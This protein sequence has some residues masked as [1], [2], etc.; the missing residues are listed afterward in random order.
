MTSIDDANE[1]PVSDCEWNDWIEAHTAQQ[2]L[3]PPDYGLSKIAAFLGTSVALQHYFDGAEFESGGEY[4]NAA[5]KYSAAYRLWPSLD[6]IM[7]GGLPKDAREEAI[8]KG[9]LD[10]KQNVLF[11]VIDITEA[12]ASKVVSST[13]RLLND[14]DLDLVDRVKNSIL[15]SESEGTNNPQNSW[16]SHK[17]ACMMNNPPFYA[18]HTSAPQIIGKLLHFAEQ[19]WEAGDWSGPN[20]PLRNLKHGIAGLSIR[21]AE[22]WQYEE[23]GGLTDPFHYDTDS[24]L[25]IVALLS[26]SGDFDGGAFRTY[27]SDNTHLVHRMEQ[28][29]AICFVSYKYH[30]VTEVTRGARRSLVMELWQGG[31]GHLGR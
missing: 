8:S 19:A 21:V 15:L 18:L 11:D 3:I 13:S 16:H 5:K 25:T 2:S 9:Y 22:L 6:S 29:D 1:T 26:D 30:N 27:E 4:T 12:R 14:N 31:V 23:K 7:I 24:I 10:E 28:G 20:G 17:K